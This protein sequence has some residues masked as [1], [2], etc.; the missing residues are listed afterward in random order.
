VAGSG[1]APLSINKLSYDKLGR[2]KR[3]VI[4]GD[5]QGVDYVVLA[6]KLCNDSK[7]NFLR[8]FLKLNVLINL[9][10]LLSVKLLF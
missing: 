10:Y 8:V 7:I 5:L 6:R 1:S 2:L 9:K 3:M 4:G